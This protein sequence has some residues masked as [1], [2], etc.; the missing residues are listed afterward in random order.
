MVSLALIAGIGL[1][2]LILLDAFETVVLPRRVQRH[3][4]F[5]AWFY[6]RTWRPWRAMSRLITSP[7]RR[8][9]FLGY[10][11]PLSLLVLLAMWAFGL[12]VGFAMVQYGLGSRVQMGTERVGF[13][14]LVYMSGETFFTLGFG[15]VT[16]TMGIARAVAV[17]ESGMGF[18]FLGT[19]IGYLPVIYS[20]FSEREIEISMLDARAGSPPTAAEFLRRMAGCQGQELFDQVLR[21]WERWSAKLLEG[22]LSYGVLCFFRSQHSNQSWLAALTAILDSSALVIAGIGGMDSHQ[23][24][25][26]FAAARH[27]VVDLTQVMGAQYQSNAPER[28]PGADLERLKARLAELHMALQPGA[29][30]RLHELR[31]QY[32]PYSQAL[33]V[34]LAITLPPW[35]EANGHKDNWQSGPW[36]RL[37]QAQGL[38][39]RIRRTDHF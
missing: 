9:S 37:I 20:R 27:A 28:L 12:I 6:R 1:I 39:G 32:E 29:Q 2:V 7:N 13:A 21:E 34:T 5:T 26:T 30:E 24:K 8:E 3:F 15:D 22:H 31:Q 10:F 14:T 16:P 38:G 35:I 11:G 25:L 19:V 23:A 18:G 4:R 36:D 33:A 17:L